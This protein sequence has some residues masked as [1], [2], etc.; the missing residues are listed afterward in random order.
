VFVTFLAEPQTEADTRS[1]LIDAILRE[2][3]GWPET[4][5]EREPYVDESGGYV[6]YVLS[7]SHPYFVVEAKKHSRRYR[8][9]IHR[10]RR[11]YKI[12]GVLKED[13]ML[14]ADL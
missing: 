2:V 7:T 5:I 8:L 1:K 6:D 11:Q 9:P 3:L 4:L 12:G 10:T 13:K 14:Y